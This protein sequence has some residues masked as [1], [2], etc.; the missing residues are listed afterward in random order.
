MNPS[1]SI[2]VFDRLHELLHRFRACMRKAMETVH[3]DLTL[4]EM[5]ILMHAGRQPGLTQRDLVE[6]SHADKAQMARLLAH[7]E[8]HGWLT[9]SASESDKR[10]RCLRLSAQGEALFAQ[11]RRRQESVA[12]DLLRD[13]PPSAQ[14]QLL[15]LLRQ[16]CD[17]A[18][19]QT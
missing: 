4:N 1:Q 17:S 8:A 2:E 3:P 15:T 6:H 5:R 12:A 14:T 10:V 19:N 11:L 9:R 13:C 18:E 16:A 7:L